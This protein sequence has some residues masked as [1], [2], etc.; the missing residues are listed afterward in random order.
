MLSLAVFFY[1]LLKS[2]FYFFL[3]FPSLR[4]LLQ[5]LLAKQPATPTRGTVSVI[6]THTPAGP[7]P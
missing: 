2:D 1:L 4:P 3:K 6:H 5:S 7:Q